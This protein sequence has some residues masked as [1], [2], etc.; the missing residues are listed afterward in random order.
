MA[1]VFVLAAIVAALI[2]G[3]SIYVIKLAYSR[4]WDE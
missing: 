2:I 4:K 3:S 1:I